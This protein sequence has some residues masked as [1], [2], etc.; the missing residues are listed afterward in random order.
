METVFKLDTGA[1][2][3]AFLNQCMNVSG[4]SSSRLL[5]GPTHQ[6]LKVLGQFQATLAQS[7][8]ATTQTVF[9]IDGLQTNLLSRAFQ[10]FHPCS[11]PLLLTHVR[12][13]WTSHKGSPHFSTVWVLWESHTPSSCRKEYNHMLS[14][15]QEMFPYHYAQGPERTGTHGD[16]EG[17]LPG[18]RTNPM[19][20]WEGGGAQEVRGSLDLC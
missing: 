3:T 9:V 5:Q 6:P 19:V 1:E 15:L 12:M 10:L 17:N 13:K 8:K 20:C 4:E 14:L 11:L 7:Q 16:T 2:V 18:H